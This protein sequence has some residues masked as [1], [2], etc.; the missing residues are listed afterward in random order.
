MKRLLSIIAAAAVGLSFI[1]PASAGRT[2]PKRHFLSWESSKR[3]EQYRRVM[4]K[5]V[6]QQR[7]FKVSR[8]NTT[9]LQK[10]SFWNRQPYQFST[11]LIDGERIFVGADAGAFYA[12]DAARI[13]RLWKFKTEGPVNGKAAAADGTVYFGDSKAFVYALNE[14]NGEERWRVRLDSEVLATPL[15][16]GARLYVCDMSGRLYALDRQSGGEIW[17]TEQSDRGSGFSVRRASS[18]AAGDGSVVVGSAGGTVIAYRESDGSVRWARQIGDKQSQ[19]YD[20]DTKPLIEGGRIFVSS[21]DGQ[22]KALDPATG[23]VLWTADAGGVNDI[24]FRDGRLYASGGGVLSAVDPATGDIFWQ[25]DLETPEI[26]S[27]VAGEH[28]IAVASTVD[29]VY[30][31]DSDTGDIIYER[32]VGKGSFGDPLVVADRLYLLANK[33]LLFEFKVKELPPRKRR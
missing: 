13:K 18:P 27:P 19:I 26:S 32:F 8:E 4:K 12:F 21:A 6:A 25:Q 20:I 30:L 15:V 11:P 5:R 28:F 22:M 31:I 7:R 29:K 24:L 9:R 14:E 17:H 16:Q 10:S 2:R 33:S 1:F 3:P 23:Q